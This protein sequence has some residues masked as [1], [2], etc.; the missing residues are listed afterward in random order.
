MD[1]SF[2]D[3]AELET[4]VDKSWNKNLFWLRTA[5][6]SLIAAAIA[7]IGFMP[8]DLYKE[9]KELKR[10]GLLLLLFVLFAIVYLILWYWWDIY[11]A[12][13]TTKQINQAKKDGTIKKWIKFGW[14]KIVMMIASLFFLAMVVCLILW[15]VLA[16]IF[17]IKEYF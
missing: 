15:I 3:L 8:K 13:K 5:L 6:V 10:T 17:F 12:V 14:W 11:W 9:S 16:I 7:F 1:K 2:K 4:R